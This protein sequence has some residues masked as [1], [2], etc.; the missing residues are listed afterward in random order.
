MNRWSWCAFALG[1][2]GA[3]VLALPTMANRQ[4]TTHTRH[5]RGIATGTEAD[6]VLSAHPGLHVNAMERAMIRAGIP[7]TRLHPGAEWMQTIL[8]HREEWQ[9]NPPTVTSI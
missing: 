5:H 9:D 4:R 7:F 3:V 1:G 8:D 6:H 2:R